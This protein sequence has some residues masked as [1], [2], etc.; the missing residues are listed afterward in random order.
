[1]SAEQEG[2]PPGLDLAL[3]L[4]LNSP[5][6][7]YSPSATAW[8]SLLHSITKILCLHPQ[9]CQV[10][11]PLRNMNNRKPEQ[12]E[13]MMLARRN[14]SKVVPLLCRSLSSTPAQS[15][16]GWASSQFQIVWAER[17]RLHFSTGNKHTA[18]WDAVLQERCATSE[19]Q[20]NLTDTKFNKSW[21]GSRGSSSCCMG[22]DCQLRSFW[23]QKQVCVPANKSG[24]GL[25]GVKT[26]LPITQWNILVWETTLKRV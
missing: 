7:V 18:G 6:L 19:V 1:M 25:F 5:E 11:V 3:I 10:T 20:H 14:L 17:K 4:L 16:L 15:C 2:K 22:W 9:A 21:S 13:S 23:I 26:N 12:V 24:L 8:D